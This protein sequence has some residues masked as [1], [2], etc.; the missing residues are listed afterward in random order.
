MWCFV[1]AYMWVCKNNAKT[2]NPF[3]WMGMIILLYI[4]SK[5]SLYKDKEQRKLKEL[6]YAE[7]STVSYC[8]T[9]KKHQLQ[10]FVACLK[11]HLTCSVAET[12][13]SNI[14]LEHI[15]AIQTGI[16]VF[17]KGLLISDRVVAKCIYNSIQK[18][19]KIGRN[20]SLDFIAKI[21]HQM[22]MDCNANRL[23][24]TF[25]SCTCCQLVSK[26]CKKPNSCTS[27]ATKE[28]SIKLIVHFQLYS[29]I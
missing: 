8:K 29:H 1:E 10:P 3:K 16:I 14:L 23:K 7:F 15:V 11:M 24:M 6:F 5:L 18:R 4:E 17:A 20:F 25:S 13:K 9:E 22:V 19:C 12:I 26:S 27:W 2:V 28:K 21:I